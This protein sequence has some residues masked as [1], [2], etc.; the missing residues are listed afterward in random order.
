VR[1]LRRHE[2]RGEKKK[3]LRWPISSSREEARAQKKKKREGAAFLG[4]S[5]EMGKKKKKGILNPF[6]SSVH[7]KKRGKRKRLILPSKKRGEGKE[8]K[9]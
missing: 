8:G 2:G 9:E 7:G 5:A 1:K 4:L 3:S 6:P